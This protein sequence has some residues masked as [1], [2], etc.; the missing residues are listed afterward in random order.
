MRDHRAKRALLRRKSPDHTAHF[1]ALLLVV[2]VLSVALVAGA[3][4]SAQDRPAVLPSA[5]RMVTPTR[6][7]TAI[8]TRVPTPGTVDVVDVVLT[9]GE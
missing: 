5:I 8:P 2:V 3:I 7:P 4:V 6:A 1:I 9:R